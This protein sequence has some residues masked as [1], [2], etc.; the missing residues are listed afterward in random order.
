MNWNIR[1]WI[2]KWDWW[3]NMVCDV[4]GLGVIILNWLFWGL[5][6][7]GVKVSEFHC[8]D[9]ID[10]CCYVWDVGISNC[11]WLI[12]TVWVVILLG[13]YSLRLVIW[14]ICD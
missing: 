13:F 14:V 11:E 1:I 8:L 9:W 12:W 7:L 5:G 3:A 2:S 10:L 6:G 4:W